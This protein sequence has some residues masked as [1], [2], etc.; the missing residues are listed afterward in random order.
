MLENNEGLLE[1]DYATNAPF[2]D[3]LG[4]KSGK[5]LMD[6]DAQI[7]YC[8]K[9]RPRATPR[10]FTPSR[11]HRPSPTPLPLFGHHLQAGINKMFLRRMV[12]GTLDLSQCVLIVD[13][14][15]DLIGNE[16]KPHLATCTP[17]LL[18]SC[19]PCALYSD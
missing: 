13:E 9:V 6:P 17:S 7:V 12:S 15:D 18:E 16:L 11:T 4:I 14:V 2:Y 3:R 5:D 1:R 19:L 10:G 8:L